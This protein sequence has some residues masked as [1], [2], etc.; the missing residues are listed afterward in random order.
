MEAIEGAAVANEAAAG[1]LVDPFL[2]ELLENPRYRLIVL[3]MELDIQKFI[4]N[5]DLQ[6]FEFQ[7][8]PTSYLR[9]AAHRVAQHY[10]LETSVTE[11]PP[12]KVLARKTPNSKFPVLPLSKIPPKL[13]EKEAED[14]VKI[15]IRQRPKNGMSE[16]NGNGRRGNSV[17]SYEEREEEYD[18]ARARIFSGGSSNF[19]EKKVDFSER[20]NNVQFL[21]QESEKVSAKVALFRDREKDLNDPDYDRNYHRYVRSNPMPAQNFQMVNPVQPPQFMTYPVNQIPV[22]AFGAIPNPGNGFYVPFPTPA[23]MYA[24]CY[25]NLSHTVSQVPFYQG[26][27]QPRY[28]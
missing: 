14:K 25:G 3:R 5:P 27:D 1:Q 26:F 15:V 8:F 12:N 17:K 16:M 7:H 20:N 13:S 18:K 23:M 2:V 28:G 24:H 19:E 4:E 10:F 11:T 9:C 22:P 21:A 6:E